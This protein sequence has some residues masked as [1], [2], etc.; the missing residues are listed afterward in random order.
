MLLLLTLACLLPP[1]AIDERL[2]ADGD[3][4]ESA[5][6]GGSDCNDEDATIYPGAEELC[7]SLDRNCDDF[8]GNADMDADGFS[9]CEECDDSNA[10]IHPDAQ[11]VC[12]DAGVDEDCDGLVN[13]EDDSVDVSTGTLYYVDSDGDGLGSFDMPQVASCGIEPGLTQVYGDCDDSDAFIPMPREW[14]LNGFDDDCTG[15]GADVKCGDPLTSQVLRTSIAGELDSQLGTDVTFLPDI[16]GDGLDD[17]AVGAAYASAEKGVIYLFSGTK[18]GPVT[19]ADAFATLTGNLQYDRAGTQLTTGDPDRDGELELLVAM[20]RSS[21]TAVPGGWFVS[22]L[23]LAQ[24]E[25]RSLHY[26][27]PQ[28]A[29]FSMDNENWYGGSAALLTTPDTVVVGF[30]KGNY[31][32]EG[33]VAGFS[34]AITG[35]TSLESADWSVGPSADL[36]PLRGSMQYADLDG[37][38]SEDLVGTN[39]ARDAVTIF[40]GPFTGVQSVELDY[41]ISGIDQD[42]SN[43]NQSEFGRSSAV[44]DFD[45]DG[46]LELALS[47]VGIGPFGFTRRNQ[48]WIYSEVGEQ[49]DVKWHLLG[50]PT[51]DSGLDL[52]KVSFADVDDDGADDVLWGMPA[53][54]VVW[55]V[56]SGLAPGIYDDYQF[57]LKS[58]HPMVKIEANSSN[59]E[60]FGGVIVVGGDVNGDDRPD[61]LIGD[62]LFRVDD[63]RAGHAWLMLGGRW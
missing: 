50:A 55:Q 38:G 35:I 3:G 53:G 40:K 39:Y 43:K 30:G 34:E 20:P 15:G 44:G 29:G 7:D 9:G 22:E 8:A 18:S 17:F 57:G 5:E 61:L 51:P 25:Q 32:T 42:D 63:V 12:D 36:V 54:D 23:D 52:Q 28:I 33:I 47:S 6:L 4:F 16:D 41:V 26:G 11:E 58:T 19:P 56:Y 49:N 59:T 1:E 46:L 10:A 45:G 21:S 2:D 24:N 37:D 27:L 31:Q 62:P 13:D 14:C 60:A 48:L